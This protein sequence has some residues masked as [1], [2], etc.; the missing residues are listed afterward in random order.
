MDDV[1]VEDAALLAGERPALMAAFVERAA[2]ED[3]QY[4]SI[5]SSLYF[6]QVGPQ[7]NSGRDFRGLTST[8]TSQA[9]VLLTTQRAVCQ[10]LDWGVAV[11]V[12]SESRQ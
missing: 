1:D 10:E 2:A 9:L 8:S 12:H 7:P 11:A 6:F 4:R 3:T 5:L